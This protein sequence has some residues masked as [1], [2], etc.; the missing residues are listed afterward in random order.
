MIIMFQNKN[1]IAKFNYTAKNL[2]N[3]LEFVSKNTGFKFNTSVTI[4]DED[5]DGPL[6]SMPVKIF[7]YY[8]FLSWLFLFVVCVDM[9]IRKTNMTRYILSYLNSLFRRQLR[10]PNVQY[11]PMI[12]HHNYQPDNNNTNHLHND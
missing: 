8:L 1:I 7:D 5:F 3:Y 9:L 12:Q 2:T 6:S 10:L 4:L 11:R